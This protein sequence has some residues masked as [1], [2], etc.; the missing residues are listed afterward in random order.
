VGLRNA[1]RL[2]REVRSIEASLDRA[3]SDD[4]TSAV[5]GG[6]LPWATSSSGPTWPEY[7]ETLWSGW[8]G[9]RALAMS[10]PAFAQGVHTIAGTCGTFPFRIVKDRQ[11][12][13]S[14]GITTQPDP[15]Q[16]PSITWTRLIED[17]VLFPYAWLRV[18]ERYTPPAGVPRGFPKYAVY[19][20]YEN[21]TIDPDTLRV[22]VEGRDYTD[23]MLRF[24]SP[25]APGAL[26][27]GRR[28]LTTSLLIE[29]A[30]RRFAKMDIPA[31]YLQQTGGP[32]MLDKDIIDLLDGW[33]AARLKRSTGFL[34]PSVRYETVAF[35][36][37]QLQLVEARAA[38][39]VDLARLLN[40]PPM[41]VNAETG[42]SL[43]YSTTES[44]N[45][46]LLNQTLNPYL[47]ALTGRLSM[48]DITPR[49]QYVIPDLDAFLRSDA[50][51][52]SR[53]YT[54]ALTSEWMTTDE[55]RAAENLPPLT[56]GA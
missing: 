39:A 46:M 2:T 9:N 38:N 45:R 43:T 52:R 24:D 28:I 34:N 21:V 19:E 12:I 56:P 3:H 33:E 35:N 4:G 36:A 29:E 54:A 22:H 51:A 15:D 8:A 16:P 40:L 42:G 53:V 37:Q 1:L 27:N 25:V 14:W 7:A 23:D 13:P 48:G 6:P 31:G 47:A 30:V 17:M 32:D 18:T 11:P 44:Q 26:I 50:E 55:V 41:S 5:W 10:I 49:G 20:P